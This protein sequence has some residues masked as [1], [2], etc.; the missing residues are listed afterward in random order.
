MV[1]LDLIFEDHAPFL[2]GIRRVRNENSTINIVDAIYPSSWEVEGIEMGDDIVLK[3]QK[4]M[5][6]NK[7]Y[8]AMMSDKV[9]FDSL[10]D[11]FMKIVRF[12]QEKERKKELLVTK[13]RELED[14][15]EKLTSTELANLK[16][17]VDDKEKLTTK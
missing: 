5:D 10:L 8:W 6:E 2:L 13:R 16:L 17:I 3:R 7:V 12:N 11:Y 9:S 15:F 1:T 14:M 4:N